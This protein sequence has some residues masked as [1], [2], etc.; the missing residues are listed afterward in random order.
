MKKEASRTKASF[1]SDLPLA[2]SGLFPENS[3]FDFLLFVALP[4]LFGQGFN[5]ALIPM[6]VP[7]NRRYGEAR[8]AHSLEG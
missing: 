4:Q 5:L 2:I 6:A 8:F 1:F 3:V 7:Y